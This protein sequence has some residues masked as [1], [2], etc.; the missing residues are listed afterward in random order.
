MRNN[1]V[2]SIDPGFDRVGVA[3]LIKE[4]SKEKL[5][6]SACIVTDR[7]ETKAERLGMIGKEIKKILK[8]WQPEYLAIEKLFFNQNTTSAIGVAEARG[9]ILYEASLLG[10]EVFEYG[11][12]EI[13]IATTGFGQATKKQVE[14]MVERILNLK[15]M[16]ELDDEIDAIAVGITHLASVKHRRRLSTHS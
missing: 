13:K 2:V 14:N 12:Q 10:L 9:V 4:N 15:Q 6:Y 11:P 3:V 1:C 8:K 5:L 7:K 16:P